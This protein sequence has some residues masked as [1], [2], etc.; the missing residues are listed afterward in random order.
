MLAFASIA[1]HE[2]AHAIVARRRQLPASSITMNIFASTGVFDEGAR[3]PGA[4]AAIALAGPLVSL[5]LGALS[6]VIWWATAAANEPLLSAAAMAAFLVGTFNISVGLVNF[7]PGFPLDG[8]RIT[9]AIAWRITGNERRGTRVAARIGRSIGIVAMISGA[10]IV[11]EGSMPLGLI[12]MTCGW[13]LTSSARL[14]DRRLLI[15]QLTDGLKVEDAMERE[16][17]GIPAGLTL[18]TFA[19]QVVAE[20][21]GSAVPVTQDGHTVGVIQG[22]RLRRVGRRRWPGLRAG[23]VMVALSALPSLG[24]EIDLWSGLALLQRSGFDALPVLRDGDL[25]GL[26]SRRA[27]TAAVRAN[28]QVKT[29]AGS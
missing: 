28:T 12:G 9:R 21:R 23:E 18:D 16:M 20:T 27:V 29:G 2:L 19:E 7:V 24:P 14:M 1:V 17:T 13:L 10:L 26:L 4:D 6:L 5:V 15:E 8:G 25:L 22:S 11:L 3:A